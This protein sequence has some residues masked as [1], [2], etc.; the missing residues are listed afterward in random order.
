M[1]FLSAVNFKYYIQLK[2]Y[3]QGV[4]LPPEINEQISLSIDTI[5]DRLN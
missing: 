1:C 5:T 4:F 3:N 2:K